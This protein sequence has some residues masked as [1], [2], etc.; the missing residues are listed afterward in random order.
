MKK[1]SIKHGAYVPLQ[2]G[3]LRPNDLCSQG[4]TPIEG[5]YVCGAS[6]YPGGMI[7]G[8]GG[9]LGAN[10]IA[11]DLGVKKTWKEPE[12]VT[13]AKERGFIVDR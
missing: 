13:V 9:Y 1:G 11:D 8:A 12:F 3:Y 4:F 10:L 5:F 2:M 7:L 6:T